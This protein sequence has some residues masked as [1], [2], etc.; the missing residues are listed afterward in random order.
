MFSHSH[1]QKSD[2]IVYN[3]QWS[4]DCTSISV[5]TAGATKGKELNLWGHK[6]GLVNFNGAGCSGNVNRYWKIIHTQACSSQTTQTETSWLW[7]KLILRWYM[8]DKLMTGGWRRPGFWILPIL[9][10]YYLL[11]LERQA[12]TH[13]PGHHTTRCWVT[14]VSHF[15][16]PTV[17]L[18]HRGKLGLL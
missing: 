5:T 11:T 3:P 8:L 10:P 16:V 14:G 2:P 13:R 6:Q 9:K 7:R 4:K 18:A 1:A 17:R 12:H 15:R